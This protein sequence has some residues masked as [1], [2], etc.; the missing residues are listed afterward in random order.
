MN[1]HAVGRQHLSRRGRKVLGQ[2]ALVAAD[3]HPALD[4]AG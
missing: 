4:F 3:H 2:E 1:R